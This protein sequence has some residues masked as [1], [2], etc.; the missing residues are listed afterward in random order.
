[1]LKL[2]KGQVALEPIFDSDY[3]NPHSQLIKIPD[4]AKDRCDQGII[5]YMGRDCDKDLKVGQ[6]VI[7]SGYTGTTITIDKEI[8]I[9]LHSDFIKAIISEEDNKV[10]GL[11]FKGKV[12]FDP[13]FK[14][15]FLRL[16]DSMAELE[17]C[18]IR[19][20]ALYQEQLLIP[21]TYE[22]SISL[23]AESRTY[24]DIKKEEY[25]E[26]RDEFDRRNL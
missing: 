5:K 2:K 24:L 17:E 1:M 12:S 11:Y 20:A 4:M 3:Y 26:Q 22:Q 21:A 15:Y 16:P 23:I 14:N 7:I 18:M 13:L 19:F 25:K 8:L 6:H 9:I 10:P